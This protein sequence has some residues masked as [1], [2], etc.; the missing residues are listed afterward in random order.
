L[1]LSRAGGV[2]P[3]EEL[4]VWDRTIQAL[5]RQVSA[6]CGERGAL[7]SEARRFMMSR[8]EELN[9]QVRTTPVLVALTS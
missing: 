7:L 9:R 5:V 4:Q 3:Q 6:V 2:G 1:Q 8:I